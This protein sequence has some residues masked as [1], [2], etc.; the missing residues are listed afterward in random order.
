MLYVYRFMFPVSRGDVLL[1]LGDRSPP[2]FPSRE[3]HLVSPF[4]S[5]L[6]LYVKCFEALVCHG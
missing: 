6:A 4:E 5:L 2:C 3:P 1:G